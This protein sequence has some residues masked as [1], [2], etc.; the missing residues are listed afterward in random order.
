MENENNPN[1]TEVSVFL[2][3]SEFEESPSVISKIISLSPTNVWVRGDRISEKTKNVHH[4][5]GWDIIS[6][7][8]IYNPILEEHA[9]ALLDLVEPHFDSFCRLPSTVETQLVCCVT[10]YNRTAIL[11]FSANTIKRLA[12]INAS[13]DISYYDLSKT[14]PKV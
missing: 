3:L 1:K 11:S 2:V 8:D 13:I 12:Q 7:C 4:E 9:A 6:P 10:D 14:F 5:N